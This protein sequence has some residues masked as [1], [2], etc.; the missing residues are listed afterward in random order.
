MDI[1][2]RSMR[3]LTGAETKV[4]LALEMECLKEGCDQVTMS[5][6]ELQAET[7]LARS[8]LWRAVIGLVDKGM[9]QKEVIKGKHPS[10]FKLPALDRGRRTI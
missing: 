5:N 6:G 10:R 8:T 4:M 7:G 3:K 2:Y 1:A 9:V